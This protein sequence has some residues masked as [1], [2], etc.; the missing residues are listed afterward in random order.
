[1]R[2]EALAAHFAE[3]ERDVQDL[4]Q[5]QGQITVGR[6]ARRLAQELTHGAGAVVRPHRE[7]LLAVGLAGHRHVRA[8][9]AQA[10]DFPGQLDELAVE[11]AG[12]DLVLAPT[13]VDERGHVRER[14][15]GQGGVVLQGPLE[16]AVLLGVDVLRRP[17]ADAREGHQQTASGQ[18]TAGRDLQLQQLG[19]HAVVEDGHQ[20]LGGVAELLQAR[21]AA[22][23]ALVGHLLAVAQGGLGAR[24]HLATLGQVRLA[25]AVQQAHE[26]EP[27]AD[28]G[29]VAPDQHAGLALDAHELEG[30]LG[31]TSVFDVAGQLDEHVHPA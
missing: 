17:L 2:A 29:A 27:V 8:D 23:Q 25:G 28:A 21:G 13:L 1:M 10:G 4:E 16:R 6:D 18:G 30:D 14:T 20:L 7:T 31:T 3:H 5:A 11:L 22:A 9:G 24:A 12:L 26:G 19:I 15:R